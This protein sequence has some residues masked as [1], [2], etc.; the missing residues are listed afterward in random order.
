MQSRHQGIGD[1]DGDGIME[2]ALQYTGGSDSPTDPYRGYL[3][4]YDGMTGDVKFTYDLKPEFG[5]SVRIM[6]M[7]TCDIDGDGKLEYIFTTNTGYLVAMGVDGAGDAMEVRWSMFFDMEMGQ[8]A[9][10]DVNG[11]GLAE[12][13]FTAEDGYLY[14]VGDI[15][16]PVA[17]PR[18]VT[19]IDVSAGAY[20]ERLAGNQNRL[21]ITVTET[22]SNGTINVY[23]W[24]G[25]IDNNAA[26]TYPVGPYSVYVD[27]KGNDQIRA[28]YIVE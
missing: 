25:L 5:R 28:C 21:F 17:P 2:I 20:V 9:I 14:V 18:P 1:I 4:V 6:N 24:D 3:Y 19:V 22:L 13:I 12:I 8:P 27:T 23:E 15:T 7:L 16:S 10:A 11:D 26:G